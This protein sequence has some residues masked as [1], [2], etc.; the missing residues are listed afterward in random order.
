MKDLFLGLYEIA[1]PFGRRRMV[2]ACIIMAAQAVMQLA[3][4]LAILPFLSAAADM[5][6]FRQS[7]LGTVFFA[8]F[9]QMADT[10]AL[11]IVGSL[12]IAILLA[13]NVLTVF[14][15][16]YA[17]HYATYVGHSTRLALLKAILN[18]PYEYFLNLNSSSLIKN[19]VEDTNTMAHYVLIPALDIISR[20]FVVI[21]LGLALAIM[22]PMLTLCALALIVGYYLLVVQPARKRG[23][24]FSVAANDA[25]RA[26][27]F[28]VNETIGAIKPIIASDAQDFFRERVA[29]PS[30]ELAR[31]MPKAMAIPSIPRA[32][33][34]ILVFGGMIAWLLALLAS[35]QDLTGVMP[36]V[37][38]I[39]LIAYR[40]MPSMQTMFAQTVLVS[41]LTESVNEVL[42]LLRMQKVGA[43]LRRHGAAPPLTWSSEVRFEDVQFSYQGSD[44]QALGGLDFAIPKGKR[45]AFVGST[46][47]GK[48][49]LIDLVLGLLEP[50]SGRILVDGE[51]LTDERLAQWRATVGYVPQ[52][53]FLLNASIA[54]NIAFGQHGDALDMDR[55]RAAATCVSAMDFIEAGGGLSTDVGERGVRLSGGQRQRLALAR[56]IYSQPSLLVLDEATSALDP[57]TEREVIAAIAA[58]SDQLT[59]I[60]VAHRLNTIKD[61]DLI[62]FLRDGQIAAS[63]TYAQLSR[64]AAFRAFAN[65]PEPAAAG[66][67]E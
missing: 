55:V 4:V 52:E 22:E 53:G 30:G 21:L 35:G 64:N 23:L 10:R 18:R 44:R 37:G 67:T 13:A 46:G 26:T 56:A 29:V 5:E 36:R 20:L 17:A 42:A 61:C 19:L 12:S 6:R 39:A 50:S 65:H 47:S 9:G 66:D 27:Y 63:G 60:N 11:M 40:L 62:Y 41:T 48:S 43:T 57:E 33:L 14:S 2:Y 24:Q 8:I 1:R 16:W 34:E 7:Q 54:E 59:V 45:I 31:I 3:S 58:M 28:Q 15:G 49:T 51:A 25:A 38:V 32:G